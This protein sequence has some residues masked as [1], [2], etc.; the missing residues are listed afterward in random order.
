MNAGSLID[1][2]ILF[3]TIFSGIAN[4]ALYAFIGLGFAFIGRSTGIINFAQGDLAILGAMISSLLCAA[5]LPVF[6]AVPIAIVACGALSGAFFILAI[7]PAKRASMSQ[8]VIVTIG[9]SILIRGGMTTLWGSSPVSVPPF[10]GERP[11]DVLG[12]SILPQELWLL[13]MLALTGGAMAL[14]FNK[15]V[16]GLSLRAGASNALGAAYVGIDKRRLGFVAFVIAGLLAGLGGAVWAPI[17]Y[18]QVDLGV[19][20]GIKGFTAAVLGG[21]ATSFGPIA[22]GIILGLVEAMVT[23]YL[24][25]GYQEAITYSLLLLTLALRPHGLLSSASQIKEEIAEAVSDRLQSLRFTWADTVRILVGVIIVLAC[26]LYLPSTLLT[27]AVFAGID[28]LVVLGMVMLTGYAGQLSLGQGTFMMV[29]GYA[30]GYLTLTLGW[31]PGAALILGAALAGCLAWALGR[32]IFR[33]RGYYLSMAS[34]CVLLIMLNF[35]RELAWITGGPN[36][37]PGI[38]PFSIPGY[39]FVSERSFF[40]L[41]SAFCGAALLAALSLTRSQVGRALLSV[42]SNEAAALACGVETSKLKTSI[43]VFSAILASIAGSLYV[44]HLGIANPAPF[45]VDATVMQVTAL[46]LGGVL[47]LWGSF[48]G[49]LVVVLLP[50]IIVALTGSTG[51]QQV[52]GLQY[53]VFGFLLSAVV[54]VQSSEWKLKRP[55]ALLRLLGKTGSNARDVPVG[56]QP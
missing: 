42:R 13:G 34:L 39:A 8:L 36:G 40:F 45:G 49:T 16:L 31:P 37:L 17:S 46:V 47:S 2:N 54:V 19:A 11:F 52:A 55:L 14:F 35:A 44:H 21:L 50:S 5:G 56:G 9:F 23:G 10:S 48:F 26:G 1:F 22:G 20:L 18:P 25:S 38:P 33:L 27:T 15:T 28:A 53:L 51:S 43:F 4:G 12:I 41:L 6:V 29:G 24:S 32:L 3:Q 30:S 7:L